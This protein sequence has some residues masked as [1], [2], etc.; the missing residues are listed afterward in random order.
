MVNLSH[1]NSAGQATMVDVGGKL[2]THREAVAGCEIQM[3]RETFQALREGRLPKGD[4]FTVA[5]TAGILAAKRTAELVPL[6]H[7]LTL[8]R[9]DISFS[10]RP[11]GDGFF[12]ACTVETTAKTGVEMEALTGAAVAALTLYDMAKAGD[13]AMVIGGLRLLRKTGGKKDDGESRDLDR[14]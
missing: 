10:V 14:E 9:I 4:A 13:P 6:C 11:P 8:D 2:P 3:N 1:F 12:V 5:K 7:P